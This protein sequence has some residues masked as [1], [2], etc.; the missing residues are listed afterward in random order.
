MQIVPP[1]KGFG[2]TQ[3]LSYNNG[4]AIERPLIMH[5][6]QLDTSLP[7]SLP[8]PVEAPLTDGKIK[9]P[10]WVE[11]DRKVDRCIERRRRDNTDHGS[12]G[13]AILRVFRRVRRR[14]S[15]RRSS[16]S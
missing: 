6:A 5:D 4:Y 16:N 15:S 13:P 9:Y 11:M 10:K 12:V 7:P 2:K 8:P 3:T 14:K 1:K